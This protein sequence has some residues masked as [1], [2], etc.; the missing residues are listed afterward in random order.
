MIFEKEKAIF[1]SDAVKNGIND[2]SKVAD[3][4][5]VSDATGVMVAKRSNPNDPTETPSTTNDSNVYIGVIT[6][7][8]VDYPVVQ[9]RDGQ[10]VNAEFGS[11]VTIGQESSTHFDIDSGG[12]RIYAANGITKIAQLG[13][14]QGSDTSGYAIAPF[15]E[16]GTRKESTAPGNYSVLE[17]DDLIATGFASRVHG[18]CAEAKQSLSN[19]S[20]LGVS[21]ACGE[22]SYLDGNGEEVYEYD[23]GG[24]I[25]VIGTYNKPSDDSPLWMNYTIDESNITTM[26]IRR[27]PYVF[28]IGNGTSDSHR[29]NALTVDWNGNVDIAS[30]AKYKINGR[31]Y[32]T[33]KV[34]EFDNKT[35]SANDNQIFNNLDVS[36]TGY[37]PIG[38]VGFDLSNASSNPANLTKCNVI[39]CKISGSNAYFQIVNTASSQAKIKI[40]A[41]VLYLAN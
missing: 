14:G 34:K 10:V 33:T 20:G 36:L 30:G 16:F 38:I 2:A 26:M 8:G 27:N 21:D 24:L 32:I 35:I 31:P 40:A 41:T 23:N 11:D 17:G 1:K 19:I 5:M 12:M 39:A 28:V 6:K 22:I 25:S 4:Y 3:N 18:K 37:T 7:N 29:S 15:Y 9:I 13:Y